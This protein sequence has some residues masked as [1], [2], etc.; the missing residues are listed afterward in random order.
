MSQP[1]KQMEWELV[2][3]SPYLGSRVDYLILRQL[4]VFARFSQ[5]RTS[6]HDGVTAARAEL[7]PQLNFSGVH[8]LGNSKSSWTDRNGYI[9]PTTRALTQA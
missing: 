8:L 2:P 6:P 3:L 7:S 9:T 5:S 4:P 1:R